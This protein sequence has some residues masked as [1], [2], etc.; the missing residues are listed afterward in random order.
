MHSQ[1]EMDVDSRLAPINRS[2]RHHALTIGIINKSNNPIELDYLCKLRTRLYGFCYLLQQ[3]IDTISCWWI[4]RA[5]WPMHKQYRS[6]ISRRDQQGPSLNQQWTQ[7]NHNAKWWVRTSL[8][9]QRQYNTPHSTLFH[10]AND[11][12]KQ[13]NWP[14]SQPASQSHLDG[15]RCRH[16]VVI[17]VPDVAP[18]HH[19]HDQRHDD[20]G[21]IHLD[22]RWNGLASCCYWRC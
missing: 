14:S 20:E 11:L 17:V 7:Y 12:K 4:T 16:I 5:G 18:N 8:E 3:L 10:L 9:T 22:G 21:R 13:T 1:P 6:S 2:C 19:H 15:A